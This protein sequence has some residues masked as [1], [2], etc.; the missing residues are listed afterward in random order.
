V[1]MLKTLCKARARWFV[2]LSFFVGSAFA[3][4]PGQLPLL[5]GAGPSGVNYSVPIQTLLFLQR[6][7][8]FLPFC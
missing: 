4:S 5:V 7:R 8:S 3:Q 2:L 6:C 1:Q